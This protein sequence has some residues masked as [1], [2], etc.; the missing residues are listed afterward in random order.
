MFKLEHVLLQQ[1]MCTVHLVLQCK[2]VF[3]C[4]V[5]HCIFLSSRLLDNTRE[6][7][8]TITGHNLLIFYKTGMCNELIY[9]KIKAVNYLKNL[10]PY[11]SPLTVITHIMTLKSYSLL[12]LI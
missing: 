9:I 3:F 1:H 10:L 4:P 12:T 5:K 8:N 6:T 7:P 2:H 11:N